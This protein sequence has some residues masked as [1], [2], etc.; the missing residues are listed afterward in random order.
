MMKVRL[1][2]LAA[3]ILTVAACADDTASP[4]TLPPLIGANGA[5]TSTLPATTAVAATTTTPAVAPTLAPPTLAPLTVAPATESTVAATAAGPQG[6]AIETGCVR[7]NIDF[8]AVRAAPGVD[9]TQ[10]GAIP[11][12]TCD[13]VVYAIGSDGR[14]PWLQVA[15][16]DVFGWSAESNFVEASFAPAP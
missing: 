14:I 8:A 16:G 3:A 4:G 11:P 2:A 1:L 5:T 7:S 15:S 12:G 10:V 6:A 13:V 9:Q